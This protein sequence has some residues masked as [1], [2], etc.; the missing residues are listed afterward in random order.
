MCE[1]SN[2]SN[3]MHMHNCYVRNILTMSTHGKNE[4]KTKSTF[5]MR[6]FISEIWCK[7]KNKIKTCKLN[8]R[9]NLVVSQ[10][11]SKTKNFF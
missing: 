5:G 4:R 1:H 11:N 8:L 6:S 3:N 9:L 10:K 2:N 7:T